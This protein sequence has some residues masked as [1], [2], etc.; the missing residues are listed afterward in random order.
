MNTQSKDINVHIEIEVD[1]QT[2]DDGNY[3]LVLYAL[4][5]ASVSFVRKIGATSP[6]TAADLIRDLVL[7]TWDTAPA[8]PD[9]TPHEADNQSCKH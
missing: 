4:A 2:P 3:G 7:L 6:C 8:W 5:G 1:G 9:E